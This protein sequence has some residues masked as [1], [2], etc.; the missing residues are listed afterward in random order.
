VFASIRQHFASD[1]A[2]DLGTA[3]TCVFARGR[4]IVLNE[5]SLVALN[6]ADGTIEAVGDQARDLL[7]QTP[8]QVTAV[9][10]MR[11]GVIADPD[12]AERMLN[13]FIR[14]SL[15]RGGWLRPR[16]IIGVPPGTTAVERRAVRESAR[17]ANV[18]EVHLVDESLAAALGAGMPVTEAAG[19][20]LVDIG[21]GTTDIAVIS[22]AGLV[23]GQSIRTAGRALDEA[24]VTHA[25][26]VRGLL[27]GERTAE[28]IKIAI[29]SAARLDARCSMEVQGR[30]LDGGQPVT[31]QMDDD[32]IRA[33]I[34]EPVRAIVQAVQQALDQIPPELSGDLCDRGIILTGGGALL[35]NLDRRLSAE[36]GLPVTIAEQPLESVAVGAGRML[37]DFELLERIALA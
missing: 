20:M 30:Q 7:G 23:Y 37:S 24:I 11:D 9:R 12:A 3:N 29:G 2:I 17:R 14:K 5:P 21:G 34:A 32:E 6:A 25:R 31:A 26:R 4:G 13:Y 28:R 33:A 1:L 19:N 22:L 36:T 15:T 18:R 27:I 8:G 16:V 10:P 35:R